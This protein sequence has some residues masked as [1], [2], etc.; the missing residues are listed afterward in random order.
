MTANTVALVAG[1]TVIIFI[2]Y[3]TIIRT[4]PHTDLAS[5]AALQISFDPKF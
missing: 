1:D 2:V 5:D 4:L 3:V